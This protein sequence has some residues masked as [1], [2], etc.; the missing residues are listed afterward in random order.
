MGTATGSAV[1]CM[2][3]RERS[4]MAVMLSGWSAG[5]GLAEKNEKIEMVELGWDAL[6]A[7][8][9][10]DAKSVIAVQWVRLRGD[11]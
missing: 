9:L 4:T 1:S 10:R 8:P 5:G 11:L 6:V 7:E 2:L 3:P